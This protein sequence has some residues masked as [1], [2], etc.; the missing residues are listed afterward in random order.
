MDGDVKSI[1]NSEIVPIAI[2]G[3][4][5]IV[6]VVLLCTCCCSKRC[7]NRGTHEIKRLLRSLRKKKT[8][9]Q[10]LDLQSYAFVPLPDNLASS[11]KESSGLP[12]E[13]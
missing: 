5:F 7:Y 11:V 8:D 4:V 13:H 3:T 2:F 12:D 10:P 1:S 6:I 9:S